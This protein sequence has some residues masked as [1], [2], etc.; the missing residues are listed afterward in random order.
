M[1]FPIFFFIIP[2]KS[3]QSQS[4]HKMPWAGATE[5]LINVMSY[6]RELLFG[7]GLASV[8]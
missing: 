3:L 1:I 6:D 2:Q 7:W 8:V 4:V 5:A